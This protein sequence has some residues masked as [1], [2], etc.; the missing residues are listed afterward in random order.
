MIR[1]TMTESDD[2]DKKEIIS[3]NLT[4]VIAYVKDIVTVPR[5]KRELG[6][7]TIKLEQ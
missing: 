2:A 3:K 7:E 4:Q 6:T 5:N 1:M